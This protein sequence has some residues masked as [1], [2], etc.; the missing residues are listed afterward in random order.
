MLEWALIDTD[1]L[2]SRRFHE[3][4][5]QLNLTHCRVLLAVAQNRGITQCALARLLAVD[6][7]TLGRILDHLEAGG[8]SKRHPHPHDRR[9]SVLVI[10]EEARPLLPGIQNAVTELQRDALLGF[11]AHEEQSLKDALQHMLENL[12]P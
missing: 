9:A 4:H 11:S 5:P 8:W 12:R 10:T 6:A 1:R 2:Y 3:R 7:V